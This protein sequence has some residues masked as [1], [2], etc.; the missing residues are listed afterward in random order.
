MFGAVF[1]CHCCLVSCLLSSVL[2]AVFRFH[3]CLV[4][5]GWS[6][7]I[8]GHWTVSWSTA[9][10]CF[11]ITTNQSYTSLQIIFFY[12]PVVCQARDKV[13]PDIQSIWSDKNIFPHLLKKNRENDM[14]Q[15]NKIIWG[16]KG[17]RENHWSVEI[18]CTANMRHVLHSS[19]RLVQWNTRL[20]H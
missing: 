10:A 8:C 19:N 4:N 16:V 18:I 1:R 12:K 20:Q 9:V 5:H 11:Q 14:F 15:C 13:L 6:Q 3:C 7:A 2:L 17:H